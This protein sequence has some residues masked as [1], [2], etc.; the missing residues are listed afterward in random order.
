MMSSDI[1]PRHH[2]SPPESFKRFHVERDTGAPSARPLRDPWVESSP[3]CR[4]VGD[5][6]YRARPAWH[7]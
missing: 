7:P 5:E 4:L 3:T 1:A 6:D 2:G